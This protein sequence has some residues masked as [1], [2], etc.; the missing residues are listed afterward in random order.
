MSPIFCFI[1]LLFYYPF[2]FFLLYIYLVFFIPIKNTVSVA[3]IFY[4]F[5]NSI[6]KNLNFTKE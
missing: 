4:L 1:Q 5:S 3:N 2:F 6:K